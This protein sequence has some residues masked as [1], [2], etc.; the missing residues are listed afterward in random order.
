MTKLLNSLK[1]LFAWITIGA[2]GTVGGSE[3][4]ADTSSPESLVVSGIALLSGIINL[5]SNK[6]KEE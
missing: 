5:I 1:T 3:L 4:L 6:K 2:G